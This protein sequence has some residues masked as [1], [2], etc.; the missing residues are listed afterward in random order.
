MRNL[1]IEPTDKTPKIVFD[2][3]KKLY[4]VEGRSIP[5]DSAGFYKKV[6]NW[7]DQY[8]GQIKEPMTIE[9]RLEYFNTSSSKCLL[10]MFRRLEK[11]H[12][13]NDAVNV[14]WYVEE[15]DDDMLE[16]GEDY[17]KLVKLPFKVVEGS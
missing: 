13:A 6:Y 10:D 17:G 16:A 8:G 12:Q 11:L 14:I 9:M 2:V 5:E 15:E 4:V 1:I 3:E 7:L